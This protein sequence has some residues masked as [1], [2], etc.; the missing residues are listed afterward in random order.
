PASYFGKSQDRGIIARPRTLATEKAMEPP[1]GGPTRPDQPAFQKARVTRGPR[2]VSG[3]GV[4]REIDPRGAHAA[5]AGRPA[6]RPL[7]GRG[8]P[9]RRRRLAPAFPLTSRPRAG[10]IG[11][12][13]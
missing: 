12:P 9:H 10:R 11:P 2:G 3:P 13:V 7:H 1:P 6:R 8:P 4:P 5:A